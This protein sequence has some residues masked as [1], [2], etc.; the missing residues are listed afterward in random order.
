MRPSFLRL[1]VLCAVTSIAAC[2][3]SP[4]PAEE[5]LAASNEAPTA[6]AQDEAVAGTPMPAVAAESGP[7]KQPQERCLSLVGEQKIKRSAVDEVVAAGLGHWLQGVQLDRVLEGRK[8]KGWKIGVLHLENPCYAAVDLR[9]GDIVTAI[10][11]KGPKQ[12]ERPETAQEIFAS[13][14]K[15]P[16]IEVNYIRA[17]EPRVLRFDI[18][19]TGP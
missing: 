10:N 14:K 2:A 7:A 4:S 18:V 9:P 11:G 8:F 5:G 17:G 1:F 12:L 13:L 3:H 6:V 15:S 16:A 19:N